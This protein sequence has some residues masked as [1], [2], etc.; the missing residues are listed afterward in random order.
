MRILVIAV[1]LTLGGCA[2]TMNGMVRSTGHP[3][4]IAYTQSMD[5]DDLTVTMPDG[6]TFTGKAVMVGKSTSVGY[7]LSSATATS[8]KGRYT[9]GSGTG[10]GVVNTYTGNMQAVL[11]GNRGHTMRCNLQYADSSGYTGD[12]GI[13]LCETSDGRVIDVQW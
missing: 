1:C 7:G 10:F 4:S 8:S 2:G 12:G 13:G 6:E 11:F 9:T 3:V 5:H